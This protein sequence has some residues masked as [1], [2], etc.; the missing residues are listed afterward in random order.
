MLKQIKISIHCWQG[1]DVEGFDKKESV[2][3][4]GIEATGNFP[5]KARNAKEL[6]EDLDQAIKLIP[7]KL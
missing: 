3:G 5:G 7:G 4:G 2:S 1:D 6:R